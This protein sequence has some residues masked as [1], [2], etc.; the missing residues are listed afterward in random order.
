MAYIF[1][2]IALIFGVL[3]LIKVANA[4]KFYSRA[5]DA[6][7]NSDDRL[8]ISLFKQALSYANDKP[9]M[10][11]DILA[12]LKELYAKHNIAFDFGDYEKL[13]EQIRILGKKSSNKSM[14]EMGEVIKLKQELIVTMPEL[15]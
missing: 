12:E 8:A 10:E 14:R 11:T 2:G 7:T 5:I 3:Y 1:L 15:L 13:I 4:K 6:K 9:D